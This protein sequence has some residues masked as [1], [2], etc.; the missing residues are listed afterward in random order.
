MDGGGAGFVHWGLMRVPAGLWTAGTAIIVLG[1]LGAT[2]GLFTFAGLQVA[3]RMREVPTP[4]LRGLPPQEAIRVLAD[5][6][7]NARIEPIRRIHPAIRPG[8]I[9]EQDPRSGAVTR[10][11]R[12]VK[13]WLSS[14]PN[15][16]EAP[17]LIGE[18]E[19]G[20][21]QRLI[22]NA[23]ILDDVSEIR[24]S[25]Y[26]T[27]AVVAQDPPPARSGVAVSLLINRGERGRTYVMPNLIGVEGEAAADVLRSRGFRVSV[28]GDH[29]YPGISPGIVIDQAPGAGFQVTQADAISLEVS[30]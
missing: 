27:N 15:A 18:S 22:D 30:R 26:P 5:S 24:S 3:I 7:L 20:A 25:R 4:D 14:G 11:R 13:I 6:G 2:F 9:A 23:F 16:G 21:R 29:P 8:R 19:E 1:A 10:R 28:V 17:S 12:N